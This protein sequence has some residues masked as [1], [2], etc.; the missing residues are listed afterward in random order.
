MNPPSCI[1][2]FPSVKSEDV[3]VQRLLPRVSPAP[4]LSPFNFTFLMQK[5]D[6]VVLKF[7]SKLEPF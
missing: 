7:V 2:L 3:P 1:L 4:D 5:I 6:R